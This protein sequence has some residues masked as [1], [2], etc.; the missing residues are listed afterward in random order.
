MKHV[1]A[2]FPEE[3]ERRRKFKKCLFPDR[4]NKIYICINCQSVISVFHFWGLEEVK[5]HGIALC[6]VEC[7]EAVIMDVMEV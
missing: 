7:D 1:W 4:D 5:E 6:G 2:R 3:E